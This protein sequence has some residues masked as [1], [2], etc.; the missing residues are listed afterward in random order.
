MLNSAEHEISKANKYKNFN[1][2]TFSSGSF[3]HRMLFF[4]L[5]N[6]NM[7]SVV[8][9]LTFMSMEFLWN[10]RILLTIRKI[11]SH[12]SI[13]LSDAGEVCP[14]LPFPVHRLTIS[15]FYFYCAL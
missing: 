1:K 3:K 10:D 9:I 7:R 5:I 13:D 4:R 2:F 15:S 12:S 14:W 6:V 11:A 8:G